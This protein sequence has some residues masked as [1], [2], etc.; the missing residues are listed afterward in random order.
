MLGLNRQTAEHP[1]V[2]LWRE[3]MA[4]VIQRTLLTKNISVV[5][6]FVKYVNC[7]ELQLCLFCGR[8]VRSLNVL[9]FWIELSELPWAL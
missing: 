8:Y 1:K 3:K 6:I 9:E 2:L 4:A 5:Y 7:G